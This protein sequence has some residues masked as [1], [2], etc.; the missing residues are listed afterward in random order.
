MKLKPFHG[1]KCCSVSAPLWP[2]VKNL[3]NYWTDYYDILYRDSWNPED[4]DLL[5]CHR[6]PSKSR[7]TQCVLVRNTECK[8]NFVCLQEIFI[9][10][11][12]IFKSQPTNLSQNM[13]TTSPLADGFQLR[14]D[15]GQNAV[16]CR[17]SNPC[18]NLVWST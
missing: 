2:R 17:L 16:G 7:C 5:N 15:S 10:L 8:H 4:G 13:W 9:D 12:C 18:S 11:Y 14:L 3:N 1:W 6:A